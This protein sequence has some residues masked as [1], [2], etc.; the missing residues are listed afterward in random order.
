MA[1]GRAKWGLAFSLAIGLIAGAAAAQEAERPVL[2]VHR[3]TV[4]QW[5]TPEGWRSTD[6]ARGVSMYGPDNQAFVGAIVVT[7]GQGNPPP[8]DLLLNW[9]THI[10]G[11]SAFKLI[12]TTKLPKQPI[13]SLP[14]LEW[15]IG[16]FELRY[17]I[18][19]RPTTGHWTVAVMSYA[20]MFFN[21]SIVGY[22]AND[23]HWDAARLYLPELARSITVIDPARFGGLETVVPPPNRPWEAADLQRLFA[24]RGLPEDRLDALAHKGGTAYDRVRSQGT[25]KLLEMPLER[26]D[27]ARGGYPDPNQ[28]DKLLE[29]VH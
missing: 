15:N 11:Y 3:G 7:Q 9:L 18:D 27:T 28:P 26:Y 14:G 5:Y 16:E 19:G 24:G 23:D 12:S 6:G 10:R 17:L 1:R 20:M 25:G 29:L 22:S 21:G 13:P 8:Q 2:E 4:F